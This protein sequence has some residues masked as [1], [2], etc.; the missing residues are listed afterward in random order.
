M[1]YTTHVR[2]QFE[3]NPPLAWPEIKDT[4]FVAAK[5]NW[6]I[7]PDRDLALQVN[8]TSVEKD[9][10]ILIS[11]TG[12]RLVM[13]EIDDYRARDL[14]INVQVTFDTFPGHTFTG[15]LDCEGEESGDLWRVE[16]ENGNQAVRSDPMI[17]WP[18]ENPPAVDRVL[19]LHHRIDASDDSWLCE[20]CSNHGDVF[21]PCATVKAVKG[22]L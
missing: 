19:A 2:G 8:E 4:G 12:V 9:N 16:V 20:V 6:Y 1:G 5:G 15:H 21:W 10:D 3:I 7:H 18:G 13:Q 17:V 14:V 11:R 22:L